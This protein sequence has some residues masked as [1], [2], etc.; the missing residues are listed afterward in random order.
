MRE[1]KLILTWVI[2]RVMLASGI[3]NLAVDKKCCIRVIRNP[4]VQQYI[5]N[6]EDGRSNKEPILPLTLLRIRILTDAF[7]RFIYVSQLTMS[8]KVICRRLE[9]DRVQ[10]LRAPAIIL[11]SSWRRPV[12]AGFFDT[13]AIDI[14]P[15][16]IV[17]TIV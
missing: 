9:V 14:T 7:S 5:G 6:P 1:A 11:C 16:T 17:S 13:A 12:S 8:A 3:I 2:R 10:I 4:R 15:A